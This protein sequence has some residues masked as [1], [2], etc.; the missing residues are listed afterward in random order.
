MSTPSSTIPWRPRSGGAVA[1][2]V[3]GPTAS[4]AAPVVFL[5][6]LGLGPDWS[7][8]PYLIER[9]A[10]D[11]PVVVPLAPEPYTLS[12]ER[13]AL[14]VLLR[15]LGG[16]ERPPGVD[17]THRGPIG[18]VGHAK[19][20]SLGL[21]VAAEHDVV[22]AIVAIAPLCAFKRLTEDDETLQRDM[23]EHAQDFH[24]EM[25]VR[26]LRSKVVLIAGEEDHVVPIVE[27][28]TVFHWMPKDG[29][30]LVLLEK[31]G[32]SLG[33]QHPFEGSNRELDRVV[34]IARELFDRELGPA[35]AS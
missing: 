17:W 25:A 20:A 23:V 35:P 33:A 12:A 29:S 32:H 2:Q 11:R 22:G 27:A 13:D 6:G 16:G 5:G 7:F 3:H 1:L 19:G 28:E 15:A 9:I 18:M 30:S 34:L 14:D 21:L 4:G 26:G 31:T 8:Y 10:L 24:L